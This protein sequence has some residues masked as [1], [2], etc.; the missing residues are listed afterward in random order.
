LIAFAVTACGAASAASWI[1]NPGVSLSGTYTDNVDLAPPGEARD[2]FVTQLTPS[3]TFRGVGAHAV[4]AGTIA[5]PMLAYAR[6]TDENTNGSNNFYPQASI[7]GNAEILDNLFFVDGSIYVTQPS[8]SAF[9]SQSASLANVDANRYTAATYRVSPYLKG[10]LPGNAQYE[11]RN[12]SVFTQTFDQPPGVSDAFSNQLVGH[13][14]APAAP[15][16][17]FGDFDLNSVK[18]ENQ[19]WQTI[20]LARAGPRYAISPQLR[21]QASAGYENDRFPLATYFAVLYGAA[22]EWRPSPRTTA[23]ASVEHRF[24]GT[25][26]LATLEYRT[27]LTVWSISASRDLT[28]FPQQLAG[29]S[30]GVGTLLDRLF[31][32]RIP[33]PL[34]RREAVDRYIEQQALPT[35]LA[36]PIT[37]FSQSILLT[38]NVT[39]TAGLTGT[40]NNV[41]FTAYYSH[42]RAI[43]G[44]SDVPIDDTSPNSNYSQAGVNAVWTN[45]LTPVV[46]LNVSASLSRTEAIAPATDRTT[47]GYAGVELNRALSPHT[48]VFI[49]ARYQ[50]LT[51]NIADPYNETGVYAGV[52]YTYR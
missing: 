47:Q 31:K 14:A 46:N 12:T 36:G 5:L 25:S 3:I 43:P 15:I 49:G 11:L 1:V 48:K 45:R 29:G 21:A 19:G 42:N 24:F 35:T 38:N 30:L 33:D 28:N 22:I 39:V 7:V 13:I 10:E 44:S 32:S 2:D 16:G 50:R 51:S 37:S 41:F 18:F 17:W 4:V 9:G 52:G 8:A 26:Y 6:G 34:L 27:P 20:N 40:R 23:Y